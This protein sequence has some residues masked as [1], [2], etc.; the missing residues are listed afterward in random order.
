VIL[1]TVCFSNTRGRTPVPDALVHVMW[2]GLCWPDSRSHACHHKVW[3]Y[4][5]HNTTHAL[6]IT[7]PTPCKAC[8]SRG[9]QV[10][11]CL[12]PLL[13]ATVACPGPGCC[14]SDKK[15]THHIGEAGRQARLVCVPTFRFRP[16]GQ[17]CRWADDRRIINPWPGGLPPDPGSNTL[18][19]RRCAGS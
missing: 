19:L 6:G 12:L 9:H 13:K 16:Q 7:P 1:I 11:L 14:T 17:V 8:A 15:E 2:S 10:H 18:R 4:A 5:T 3:H